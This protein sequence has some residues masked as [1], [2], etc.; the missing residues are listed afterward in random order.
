MRLGAEAINSEQR[1]RAEQA[2][3]QRA[4]NYAEQHPGATPLEIIDAL[5]NPDGLTVA[6]MAA[7]AVGRVQ[8]HREGS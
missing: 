4:I 5:G 6:P 1:V 3:Q 8:R 7:A 2:W